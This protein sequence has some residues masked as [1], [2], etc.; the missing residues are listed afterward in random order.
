M[1]G[2]Q[3]AEVPHTAESLRQLIEAQ[4]Q[5]SERVQ[6]LDQLAA[7]LKEGKES[8]ARAW[9][10][11][12]REQALS[13]ATEVYI[14]VH[15]SPWLALPPQHPAS[16]ALLPLLAQE[17]QEPS[18]TD[19]TCVPND[20]RELPAACAQKPWILEFE[21]LQ[22]ADTLHDHRYVDSYSYNQQAIL[23]YETDREDGRPLSLRGRLQAL[24]YEGISGN[25]EADD[26]LHWQQQALAAARQWRATG[27]EVLSLLAL[28][29][30]V[31]DENDG[32]YTIREALQAQFAHRNDLSPAVEQPFPSVEAY[33]DLAKKAAAASQSERLAIEIQLQR[34][35][36]SADLEALKA[37]ETRIRAVSDAHAKE[38]LLLR[39][40]DIELRQ[41]ILLKPQIPGYR[42]YDELLDQGKYLRPLVVRRLLGQRFQNTKIQERFSQEADPAVRLEMV[43]AYEAMS[44]A[45]LILKLIEQEK[46]PRIRLALLQILGRG[47]AEA[48][49]LPSLYRDKVLALARDP[50]AEV[51]RSLAFAVVGIEDPEL[52]AYVLPWLDS[53]LPELQPAGLWAATQLKRAE[54]IPKAMSMLESP[55]ET[56]KWYAFW[57]VDALLTPEQVHLLKAKRP[58]SDPA[59]DAGLRLL[60][61]RFEGGP[62]FLRELASQW[63]GT[64]ND[65]VRFGGYM[66]KAQEKGVIKSEDFLPWIEHADPNLRTFMLRQFIGS[67]PQTPQSRRI[68]AS[69][70]ENTDPQIQEQAL[71]KFGSEPEFRPYFPA[72]RRLALDAASP[73]TTRALK[74]LKEIAPDQLPELLQQLPKTS[75]EIRNQVLDLLR[76]SDSVLSVEHAGY[77]QSLLNDPDEH[78]RLVVMHLVISQ[79][80]VELKQKFLPVVLQSGPPQETMYPVLWGMVTTLLSSRLTE[81]ERTGL[82]QAWLPILVG[83]Y[84]DERPEIGAWRS[85]IFANLLLL[86]DRPLVYILPIPRDLPIGDSELKI[87]SEHT[88]KLKQDPEGVKALKQELSSISEPSLTGLIKQLLQKIE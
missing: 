13:L 56:T 5:L 12:H 19:P 33:L 32:L 42:L 48:K 9:I 50:D 38:Y 83:L 37:V 27:M 65:A 88:D 85:S 53:P 54:A 26:R 76:Q 64:E 72:L 79:G 21:S 77:L 71:E 16:E 66:A 74:K 58:H 30:A 73:L 60:L 20:F 29:T 81:T 35:W 8:Q 78:I 45:L 34:A 1:A 25:G 41:G 82:K 10:R 17:M 14:D 44:E 11:T 18:L 86:A 62:A 40:A 22:A 4:P 80:T 39:L 28:A 15:A 68:L 31:A 84:R 46:V 51:R 49:S 47:F 61:A 70:V 59:L 24:Y 43:R 75:S 52:P 7:W 2:A 69:L 57:T 36:L 55:D 87:L 63:T 67:N 6:Q 3:S 23:R